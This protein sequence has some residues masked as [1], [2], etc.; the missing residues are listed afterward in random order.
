MIRD[1]RFV[2][3]DLFVDFGVSG[4]VM[5]RP[6][7]DELRRIVQSDH[8]ISHLLVVRRD[9]LRGPMIQSMEFGLKTNFAMPDSRLCLWIRFTRRSSGANVRS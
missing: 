6:A 8:T 4:N 1:G 7:L 3:G 2:D 9:R 5:N